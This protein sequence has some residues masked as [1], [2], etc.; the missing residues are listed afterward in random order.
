M[1]FTVAWLPSNRPYKGLVTGPSSKGPCSK[2]LV[3]GPLFNGPLY[4]IVDCPVQLEIRVDCGLNT[5][6]VLFFSKIRLDFID[7]KLDSITLCRVHWLP[8]LSTFH[9][10]CRNL[11]LKGRPR[12]WTHHW[13]WTNLP[14]Q[15][16]CSQ[17]PYSV[18]LELV[19]ALHPHLFLRISSLTLH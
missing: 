18:Q 17:E 12:G 8:V 1:T 4:T 19:Q 7:S 6:H 14:T 15:K 9:S 3:L 2:L 16:H 5:E 11:N 13:T 10:P